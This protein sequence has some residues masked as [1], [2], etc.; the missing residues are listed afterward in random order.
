MSLSVK[1]MIKFAKFCLCR[2]QVANDKAA[3]FAR[4]EENNKDQKA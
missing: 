2:R 4:K 3:G 1:F